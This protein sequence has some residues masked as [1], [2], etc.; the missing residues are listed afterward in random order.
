[1]FCCADEVVSYC[2]F[3][4][5]QSKIPVGIK[6][7]NY[8]K[9]RAPDGIRNILCYDLLF[10]SSQLMPDVTE[11]HDDQCKHTSLF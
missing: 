4:V 3:V 7:G 6:S 1:M 8:N 9:V 2:L 11:T 10:V 5:L